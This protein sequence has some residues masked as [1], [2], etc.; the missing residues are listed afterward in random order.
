MSEVDL[1]TDPEGYARR[2]LLVIED[3]LTRV[4]SPLKVAKLKYKH[5]QWTK[6]LELLEEKSNTQ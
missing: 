5:S 2:A 1:L 3:Q 6:L 4:K